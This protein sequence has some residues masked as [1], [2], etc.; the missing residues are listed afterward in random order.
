M[1]G[2]NSGRVKLKA[3]KVVFVASPLSTHHWLRSKRKDCMVQW[4]ISITIIIQLRCCLVQIGHNNYLIECYLFFS[5]HSWKCAHLPSNNHSRYLILHYGVLWSST[6]T[7]EFCGV[8]FCT[9]EFCGDPF[10]TWSFVGFH[11][12]QGNFVRIHVVL[13]RSVEFH[14]V[15]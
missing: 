14:F 9:I 12:V 15:L 5:W 1:V 13:C 7:M 6:C 3:R 4:T 2:S 8:P 10:C 11:F